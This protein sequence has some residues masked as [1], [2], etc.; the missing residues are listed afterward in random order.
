MLLHLGEARM[1]TAMFDP[2]LVT[3]DAD[4]T[5]I[6]LAVCGPG[7]FRTARV[8][9]CKL[10]PQNFWCPP[11]DANSVLLNVIACL[12]NEVTEE[13]GVVSAGDCYCAAGF[14]INAQEDVTRCVSCEAGERCQAGE[15]VILDF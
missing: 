8:D 5:D 6:L 15:V 7:Y 13:V 14:K 11:E 2:H 9:S 1:A 10:C 12:E 4:T 3:L